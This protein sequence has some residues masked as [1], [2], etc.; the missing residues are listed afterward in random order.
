MIT[1]N[2]LQQKVVN[3]CFL[4]SLLIIAVLTCFIISIY[5][6]DVITN[7]ELRI[8]KEVLK[9]EKTRKSLWYNNSTR[10]L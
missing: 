5:E 1:L 6:D 8:Y 4:I 7:R 10:G 2:N 9:K 3:I